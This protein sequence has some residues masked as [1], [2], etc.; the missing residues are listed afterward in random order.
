MIAEWCKGVLNPEID[1]PDPGHH[2][3][4]AG[5]G[6]EQ[7]EPAMSRHGITD[8][9]SV[10]H[11]QGDAADGQQRRGM[12]CKLR[13]VTLVPRHQQCHDRRGAE[14]G[15]RHG[16][17]KTLQSGLLQQDADIGPQKGGSHHTNRSG[18]RGCWPRHWHR[19]PWEHRGVTQ[20][21]E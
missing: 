9:A 3:D 4:Q 13:L 18:L 5:D 1:L 21:G 8:V 15:D 19:S 10:Q 16:Q 17:W 12:T 14:Q 2:R 11:G 7:R 6:A 20:P